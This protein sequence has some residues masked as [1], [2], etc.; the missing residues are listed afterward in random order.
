MTILTGSSLY[1]A[2]RSAPKYV[3]MEA[4]IMMGLQ[5]PG[6]STFVKE[7]FYRTHI[8]LNLDMLK[9]R[10]RENYLIEACLHTKQPFVVDNTNPTPKDRLRNI[11]K[12][13][14][15]DFQVIGYFFPPDVEASITNNQT[16]NPAEQVPVVAIK[17]TSKKWE[18]PNYTEGFDQI[19]QVQIQ[20]S[21]FCIE[22]YLMNRN[23]RL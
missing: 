12:A 18:A 4:V 17:S 6:K 3:E 5:G 7:H 22:E 16:R 14:Q 19:Y 10:H 1:R 21:Q 8:R 20:D 23:R 15:H 9:T 13:K 11:P 2:I